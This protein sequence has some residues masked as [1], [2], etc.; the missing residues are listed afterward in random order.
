MLISVSLFSFTVGIPRCARV[1]VC[2]FA[3]AAD[4]HVKESSNTN[5]Q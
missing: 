3:T 1:F 2:V 5:S 4:V